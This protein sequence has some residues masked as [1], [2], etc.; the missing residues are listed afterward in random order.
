MIELHPNYIEKNGK[1]EFTI[2]PYEEFVSIQEELADYED[3]R[4]LREAKDKE[5]NSPTTSFAD[6][7]AEL[8][9]TKKC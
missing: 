3:L 9:F 2:L 5:S 8:G 6:V 4:I 1:R 7:K